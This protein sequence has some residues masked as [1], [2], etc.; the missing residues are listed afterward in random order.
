M[1]KEAL[2]ESGGPLKQSERKWADSILSGK[3]GGKTGK[4]KAA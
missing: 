3:P 2:E 1:L 4:R